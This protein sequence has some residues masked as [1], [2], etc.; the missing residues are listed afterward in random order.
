[1]GGSEVAEGCGTAFPRLTV[2]NPAMSIRRLGE[3]LLEEGS[4]TV[5]E[6]HTAL[7]AC[8]RSGGRLGTHLLRLGYVEERT[9]LRAL[10]R[11]FGV[12]PVPQSQLLAA[13]DS[14]LRLI[15]AEL[16]RRHRAVP[17]DDR[18]GVLAVAMVNPR[19]PVARDEL[20]GASRL[21]LEI[22]VATEVAVEAVLEAS[23]QWLRVEEEIEVGES[24]P[25][26]TD[27]GSW[28][29][30]WTPPATGPGAL[31]R[32][33]G[34]MAGNVLGADVASFPGLVPLSADSMPSLDLEGYRAALREVR[35]RDEVGE[36]LAR[37][38]SGYLERVLL[39]A[40]HRGRIAGW[41]GSGPGMSL[42]DVQAL[43]APLTASSVFSVVVE[44]GEV[45]VG[46]LGPAE[47][48]RA[49]REVLGDPPAESVVAVPVRVQER[50]VAVLV[51]DNPGS[52]P[53]DVPSREL[54]DAANRAG[55]ALEI[56]IL[57]KKI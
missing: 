13:P 24:S 35:G 18:G 20:A 19:D 31:Q 36:A 21:P 30:L 46:P 56:L 26:G 10:S 32:A 17:F 8:H 29:G 34:R 33:L 44:G 7:E 42:E 23:G 55:L 14:V 28:E 51:G 5:G 54:L 9:L 39:L 40:A 3:L 47:A 25:A 4:I 27:D 38:A 37:Y 16:Q 43:E 41:V 52:G 50:T 53:A 22:H 6:L 15:P 49:V 45:H 48:D 12:P 1:M 57:R 11:Q 2:Y